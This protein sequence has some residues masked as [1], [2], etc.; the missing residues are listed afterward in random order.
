MLISHLPRTASWGGPIGTF[1]TISRSLLN[2]V[3]IPE[4]RYIAYFYG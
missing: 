3:N 4:V 2:D 1:R